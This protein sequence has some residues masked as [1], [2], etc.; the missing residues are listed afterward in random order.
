M[1]TYFFVPLVAGKFIEKANKL[2]VDAIVY[3]LE[4]AIRDSDTQIAIDN[5]Q[6][7][8]TSNKIYFRPS[9]DWNNIES[10]IFLQLLKKGYSRFVIPKISSIIE[11]ASLITISKKYTEK[12]ELILLIENPIILF[13][14]NEL[15]KSFSNS[16]FA[17]ALGS[18]DYCS[19]MG[20]RYQYESYRFAHDY[21]L[22][23][24]RK[25]NIEAIDI[26]SM[27]INNRAIFQ[28]EVMT[29]FD[30]GYRSKFILHPKQL[31][32]LNTVAYF[33]KEEIIFAEEV[34]KAIDLDNDFSAISFKGKVLEKPHIRR[35]K[36]IL[37]YSNN[38]TK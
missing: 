29:A 32:Y 37:N 27:E 36:E 7:I 38:E 24:A 28:E 34:S 9:I 12:L 13:D 25:Y 10:G 4:D 21:V 14:L 30:K 35:I 11:L 5:I 26:A 31:E 17:I 20:A 8:K 23:I 15:L 1:K 22:N 16:I 6:L 3:D 33:E 18:H 2:D 19:L